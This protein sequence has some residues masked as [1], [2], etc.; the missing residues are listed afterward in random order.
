[1]SMISSAEGNMLSVRNWP[2]I[3]LRQEFMGVSFG[4]TDLKIP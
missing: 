4:E 2:K 1:M 3:A